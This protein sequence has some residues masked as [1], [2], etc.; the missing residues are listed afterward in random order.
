MSFQSW[1]RFADKVW[2]CVVSVA[3][4]SRVG[5]VTRSSSEFAIGWMVIVTEV[6]G[7]GLGSQGLNIERLFFNVIALKFLTI[8]RCWAHGD[9]FGI[10]ES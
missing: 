6:E 9:R 4:G 3:L 1:K 7:A 5:Q 2:L 10:I 8:Q